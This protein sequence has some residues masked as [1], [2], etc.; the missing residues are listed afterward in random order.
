MQKTVEP[1]FQPWVGVDKGV[2]QVFIPRYNDHQIIPVVL[3]G[4]QDGVDGLLAEILPAVSAQG[5][6][7][8]DEQHAAQRLF[9]DL[10]G[11]ESC[12]P[13]IARHQAAAVHL[14]QLSLGEDSQRMIDPGHDPG[15]R[16]FAGSRIAGEHHVQ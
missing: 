11:L 4:F 12:L 2:H 7:L 14:Y 9:Q 5:V 1:G 3:H 10:R 15:Y 13:Y 8:I 6:G 16:G